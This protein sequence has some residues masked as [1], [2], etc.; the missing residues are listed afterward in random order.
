MTMD[1]SATFLAAS[2]LLMIGTVVIV[3]GIIVI[4]NILHKYWKPVTLLKWQDYHNPPRFASQEELD[5]LTS[6]QADNKKDKTK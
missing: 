4:N 6:I 1:Q 2:I 5:R 3:A